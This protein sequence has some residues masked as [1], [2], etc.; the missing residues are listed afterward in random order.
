MYDLP[1]IV[2][3]TNPFTV[4]FKVTFTIKGSPTAIGV[5]TFAEIVVLNLNTVN[6]VKFN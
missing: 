4:S 1:S 6:V 2:N 5:D 3:F